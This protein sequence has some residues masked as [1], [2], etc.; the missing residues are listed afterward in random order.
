MARIHDGFQI[1]R[2]KFFPDAFEQERAV[3]AGKVPAPDPSAKEHVP[4][5]QGFGFWEEKAEASGAVPGNVQDPHL[6]PGHVAF[7]AFVEKAVGRKRLD[8]ELEPHPP[9][10][11]AVGRHGGGVR[12]VGDFAP[13]PAPDRRRIRGMV[14]VAVRQQKPVHFLP[15]KPGIGTLRRVEKD[16]PPGGFQKKSV[17]IQWP[18]GKCFELIHLGMV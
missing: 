5:D 16:V 6:D 10:K 3:A 4:A 13:V 18:A 11:A 12:V 14:E 17:G 15:G 1:Q 9:K 2:K 7:P 8:F